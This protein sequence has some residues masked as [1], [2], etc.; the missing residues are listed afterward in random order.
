MD[1]VISTRVDESV[2]LLVGTLARRLHTSKKRVIEEAMTA[3]AKSVGVAA[4]GA[5]LDSTA[6]CWRRRE[7]P[8]ATVARVRKSFSSAY[9]RH[10]G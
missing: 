8:A 1:K 10:Q 5:L 4:N 7:S 3:Y 9:R 2:A 6:G